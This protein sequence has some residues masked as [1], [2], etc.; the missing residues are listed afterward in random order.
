M[1]DDAGV[2][3]DE[4]LDDLA[5]LVLGE[6]DRRDGPE[7]EPPGEWRVVREVID[8]EAFAGSELAGPGRPPGPAYDEAKG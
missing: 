1:H 2:A 5:G 4:F 6:I 8:E 3:V 7:V